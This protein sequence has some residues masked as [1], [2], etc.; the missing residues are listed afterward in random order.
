MSTH[1]I[2]FDFGTKTCTE[3]QDL[4]VATE[5]DVKSKMIEYWPNTKSILI[6]IPSMAN[7]A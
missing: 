7:Q 2:N 4:T 5:V 6:F 1:K 3:S